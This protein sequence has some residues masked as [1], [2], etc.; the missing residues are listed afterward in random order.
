MPLRLEIGPKDVEK[1]Q[2]VLV[3]R[4]NSQKTFVADDNVVSTVT[5]SLEE[6]QTNLLNAAKR[7]LNMRR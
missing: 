6:I 2:V 7:L 1:H 5:T 3:R 4:D